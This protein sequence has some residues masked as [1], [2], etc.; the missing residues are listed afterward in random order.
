M[1]LELWM[2]ICKKGSTYALLA[3]NWRDFASLQ[4]LV[5]DKEIFQS[6]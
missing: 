5:G 4:G 2:P 1:H 3:A 6:L